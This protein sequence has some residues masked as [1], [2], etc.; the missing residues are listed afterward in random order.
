MACWL[1]A[2][3]S[4]QA[5]NCSLLQSCWDSDFTKRPEFKEV[6]DTMMTVVAEEAASRSAGN[7]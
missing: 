5:Q 1:E 3:A 4:V 6:V 7:K 2:A